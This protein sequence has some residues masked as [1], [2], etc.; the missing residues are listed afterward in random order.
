MKKSILIISVLVLALT[1]CK[2]FMDINYDPNQPA[3]DNVTTDMILPAVEMNLAA[4]YANQ[5]NI[6]GGYFAQ[7]YAHQFG[8]S[9]YLDYSQ[10]EMSATRSS[11][12][13]TQL[14]QRTLMNC[15]TI[16]EKASA[17]EDWG[18]YLAATT[19]RAFAFQ[20]LV[21]CYGEVPYTEALD[22]ANLAP[23]YDD[24]QVVYEGI[25]AELDE[26]LS[27]ASAS[28]TVVTNFTFPGKNAESWIR[29]A[30]AQKLKMLTRLA[31]KKDVSAQIQAIIDEGMLPQEDV[32]IS[33][34]WSQA[35]GQESP[36]WAEEFSTLGGSTQINVIANI[37]IIRTMQPLDAESNIEYSDPRL[38]AFWETN[39]AD[40]F[41]G[42]ISGTNNSTAGDGFKASH[43]CRPKASFNMPVYLITK[44]EVE[45]FLAEFFAKKGDAGS[46]TE[47]YNAAIEASFETAGVAGADAH[48]A[49]YPFNSSNWRESI[50]IQKWVALSGTNCFEAYTEVRRLGYPTFG[51]MSGA[52]M[53]KESGDH[54]IANYE[55]GTLHTPYL[56][57][58]KIGNNQM[59]QRWPFSENSQARN[60]STPSFKGYTTP[61]FWA[62]Q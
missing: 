62:V 24:G 39:D 13:W 15:K 51:K 57:S 50:G 45:F 12:N 32:E 55:P 20:L 30:N 61:I 5:M 43:W 8:T 4:T 48:I 3:A 38:S 47:H 23:K 6:Q 25:I 31:A 16:R 19:L 36:F 56:V 33:G 58:G 9:N 14:Y 54:A 44:A 49:R 37:A 21:D 22:P 10:F 17:E 11:L 59:L 18:T 2:K 41:V 27:K 52:Q 34:C 53:F 7:I 46:A 1:S 28:A 40:E 42:N 29:F 35:A 60:A 26:A